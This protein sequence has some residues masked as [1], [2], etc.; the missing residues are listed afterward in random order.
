MRDRSAA[1]RDGRRRLCGWTFVWG[2]TGDDSRRGGTGD[3]GWSLAS[4]LSI[5]SAKETGTAQDGTLF[6]VENCGI[7][8]PWGKRRVW[9]AGRGT[10]PFRRNSCPYIPDG[11]SGS[12]PRTTYHQE[13]PRSSKSNRFCFLRVL[14]VAE[15][16]KES[17]AM[18]TQFTVFPAIPPYDHSESSGGWYGSYLA[19]V[20]CI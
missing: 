5:T 20:E 19:E 12:G 17:P 18:V 7:V 16:R 11:S 1:P 13:H 10:G 2:T 3:C 15:R 9:H 4:L 14:Q 8:C 6:Q